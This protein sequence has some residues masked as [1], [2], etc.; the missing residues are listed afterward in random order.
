MVL[1]KDFYSPRN[2]LNGKL[3]NQAAFVSDKE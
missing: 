1:L 2:G 3:I